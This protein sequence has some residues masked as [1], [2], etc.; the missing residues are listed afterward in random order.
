MKITVNRI[1]L[2][3]LI[4][5]V[6]SLS[7]CG[8]GGSGAVSAPPVVS[9]ETF[10]L[11]AAY[12]NDVTT[13]RPKSAV[14]ISGTAEG[15]YSVTGSGTVAMSSLT[16]V[17]FES[18]NCL[19][20][21]TS[22]T[23]TVQGMDGVPH[24]DASEITEYYDSGNYNYLGS[25]GDKYS[26][27]DATMVLPETAIVNGL[28]GSGTLFTETIYASSTDRTMKGR[29]TVSFSLGADTATT[30]LLN[31]TR[32]EKDI[33]GQVVNTAVSVSRITPSGTSTRLYETYTK[34]ADYLKISY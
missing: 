11:K 27:V 5:T 29:T 25:S 10:Q 8:G 16:N 7:G 2:G 31:I 22:I 24:S 13:A 3:L 19:Q 6:F 4:T 21:V 34:G 15:G 14:T 18:Y 26:I 23:G 20:K 33:T 17:T 1:I 28:N 30:A 9:T 12:I 32:T